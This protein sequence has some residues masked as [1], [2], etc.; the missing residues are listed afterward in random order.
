MVYILHVLMLL[1]A[2]SK[3]IQKEGMINEVSYTTTPTS[4]IRDSQI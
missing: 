1:L 4:D 3:F 2:L